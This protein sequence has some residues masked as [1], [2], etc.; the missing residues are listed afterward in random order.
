MYKD[1]E[2]R[3]SRLLENKVVNHLVNTKESRFPDQE[4]SRMRVESI[5]IFLSIKRFAQQAQTAHS[6]RQYTRL[7]QAAVLYCTAHQAP[8]VANYHQHN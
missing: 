8:Q 5:P 3:S 7:L 2:L 6:W 1:L 4:I